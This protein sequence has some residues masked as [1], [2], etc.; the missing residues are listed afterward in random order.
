MRAQISGV[1]SAVKV[2]EQKM[3]NQLAKVA[4][5]TS[6]VLDDEALEQLAQ[7][8]SG[9]LV[10]Y[11]ESVEPVEDEPVAVESVEAEPLEPVDRVESGEDESVEDDERLPPGPRL[12]AAY[13]VASLPAIPSR[14]VG[15]EE[16]TESW[17]RRTL[18]TR[19]PS[20]ATSGCGGP[21][22]PTTSS[23]PDR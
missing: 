23:C 19:R 15:T 14:Y 7:S 3:S 20:A 8:V 16:N 21:T 1:S 22:R 10:G 2:A 18:T 9:E 13:A 17:P 11:L 4:K 5:A 12:V 6:V